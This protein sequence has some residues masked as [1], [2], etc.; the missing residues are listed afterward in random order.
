MEDQS[1]TGDPLSYLLILKSFIESPILLIT[2]QSLVIILLLFLSG[3]FSSLEFGFTAITSESSNPRNNKIGEN[4]YLKF[5]NLNARQALASLRI[6][7]NFLS[8]AIITLATY[9]IWGNHYIENS[10]TSVVTTVIVVLTFALLFFNE[11]FPRMLIKENYTKFILKTSL[12]FFIIYKILQPVYKIF[13]SPSYDLSKKSLTGKRITTDS[14]SGNKNDSLETKE[15]EVTADLEEEQNQPNLNF[16]STAVKEIM[17]NRLDIMAFDYNLTFDE[18]IKEVNTHGYSRIPVYKETIDNIAGIIY[19]KDLLMHM[20]MKVNYDWHLLIRP[21]FFVPE[22]KKIEDLLKDFQ[23]KKVHMAIVVDEYGGTS[24]LVTLEDILEEIVGEIDDE[25]DKNHSI[26]YSIL[27]ES[28]FIFEGKTQLTDFCK[29]YGL[30]P[31]ELDYSGFENESIGDFLLR[32]FETLPSTGEQVTFN[33]FEFTVIGVEKEKIS[34]V[35]VFI[36]D[37]TSKEG[38]LIGR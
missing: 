33:K 9:F 36:K 24:G 28:T 32:L 5:L 27:D 11:L 21:G 25:F 8:V 38:E 37:Q 29:I 19:V 10:P 23:E 34:R 6:F 26:S 18:L 30:D 16:D 17:V 35:K 3:F 7:K 1:D 2:I 14:N 31:S 13:S 15:H 22:S 12:A 4:K 20:E